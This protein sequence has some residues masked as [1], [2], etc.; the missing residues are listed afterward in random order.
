LETC[1]QHVY[2]LGNRS[3]EVVRRRY[4]CSLQDTDE[5]VIPHGR[6]SWYLDQDI[7]SV[8]RSEYGYDEED[9]VILSFGSIRRPEE[10]ELLLT[11]FEAADI[12]RKQLL[13]AGG[14][15]WPSRLS[16]RHYQLWARTLLHPVQF[17]SGFIPHEKVSGLLEVADILVIPRK[18]ALNSGNVALGF[19]FGTVV[20]GPAVGVI[21]EVLQSTENPIYDP[22]RP[23]T[24]GPALE[25]AVQL[26]HSGKGAENF[27]YADTHWRWEDLVEE[28]VAFYRTCSVDSMES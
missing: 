17:L 5:A 20:V 15:V 3:G 21:G 27:D 14:V 7:P 19:T 23:E 1:L 8:S 24:M 2:S 12:P 22:D 28:H 9:T 26:A 18:E 11:G 16:L 25:R 6:Y 10:L 4:D 13:V